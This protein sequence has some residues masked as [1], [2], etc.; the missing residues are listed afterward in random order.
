MKND[1]ISKINV[2]NTDSHSRN[3][4]TG[5][6]Q[7]KEIFNLMRLPFTGQSGVTTPIVFTG[8]NKV[9]PTDIFLVVINKEVVN[10]LVQN[11]NSLARQLINIR[12]LLYS[13][14]LCRWSNTNIY[15]MEKCQVSQCLWESF[16]IRA[17]NLI[18]K[19]VPFK[20]TTQNGF[21]N[22]FT[23]DKFE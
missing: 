15:E 3:D 1:E 13:C 14:R 16:V 7:S 11:N 23:D 10:L 18:L 22:Q 17:L 20:S 19:N 8:V 21:M 12:L 9:T 5:K 4:A 6:I 2:I